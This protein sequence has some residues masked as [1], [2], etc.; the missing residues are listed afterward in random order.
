MTFTAKLFIL[1]FAV[2]VYPLVVLGAGYYPRGGSTGIEGRAWIFIL[3]MI[4]LGALLVRSTARSFQRPVRALLT[5]T[6]A[7]EG[8]R[9]DIDIRSDYN[10]ELG[11][12]IDRTLQ[13]ARSLKEKRIM[14]ETFGKVV[15][16]AYAITS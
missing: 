2:S 1:W 4:P 8:G 6:E 11:H 14:T 7:I 13:V 16:R 15:D 3:W 5:A 12:L 10:D 9:Y